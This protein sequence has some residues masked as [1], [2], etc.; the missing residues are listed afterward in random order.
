MSN[1][2]RPHGLQ[3]NIFFFLYEKY[4]IWLCNHP[5]RWSF[6]SEWEINS[7]TWCPLPEVTQLADGYRSGWFQSSM[8]S[9]FTLQHFPMSINQNRISDT[10][11]FRLNKTSF[12]WLQAC[13][14]YFFKKIQ[15]WEFPG[16]P[17]VRTCCFHCGGLGSIPGQGTKIPQATRHGQGIK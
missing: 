17:V 16:S 13:I 12:S 6:S 15:A 10:F 8:G 4:H 14:S 2:L 3:L 11:Y 7:E 9:V 1:S 5:R